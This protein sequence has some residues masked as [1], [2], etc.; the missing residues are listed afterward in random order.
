MT[1]KRFLMQTP[2]YIPPKLYFGVT[3]LF[4]GGS[5]A[6]GSVLAGILYCLLTRHP[7]V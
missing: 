1:A 4:W 7:P 2:R 3:A 6:I 5:L